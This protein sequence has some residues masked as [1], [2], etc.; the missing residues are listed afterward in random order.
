LAG[1]ARA[2]AL[3]TLRLS[4]TRVT[5]AGLRPLAGLSRLAVVYVDNTPVGDDGLA[6]LRQLPGIT[7]II[8]GGPNVHEAEV[9]DLAVTGPT[10][11]APRAHEPLT[12]RG[13]L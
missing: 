2:T 10:G 1:L 4:G 7:R 9:R 12:V 11:A 3:H 13:R 5:D 8:A 6:F